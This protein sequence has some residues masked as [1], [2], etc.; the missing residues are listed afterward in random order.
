MP[1]VVFGSGAG[2]EAGLGHKDNYVSSSNTDRARG[3]NIV[4]I[5]R[6]AIGSIL[7]RFDISSIPPGSTIVSSVLSLLVEQF[8][9]ATN[10][11]CHE[12][13]TQWGSTDFDAGADAEP[14]LDSAATWQFAFDAPTNTPYAGGAGLTALDYNAV[15]EDTIALP[16]AGVWATWNIPVMTQNWLTN[17][18]GLFLPDLAAANVNNRFHSLDAVVPAN[19]PY[20]TIVYTV[21]SGIIR[22]QS[23]IA[24]GISPSIGF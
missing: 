1:I 18:N 2:M 22:R 11:P 8:A 13:Y 14:P 9:G 15:A 20:L 24:I 3:S 4:L 23:K 17:N 10:V 6:L 12:F 21:P 7:M 19:R 5:Y 16:I